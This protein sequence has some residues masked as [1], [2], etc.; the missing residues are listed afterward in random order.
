[1]S[2]ARE[3]SRRS[4]G[5]TAART[6]GRPQTNTAPS[7][8]PP[9]GN[10]AGASPYVRKEKDG[11][12][13][14]LRSLRE[15]YE[16]LCSPPPVGKR[17]RVR[18][19][20]LPDGEDL[21]TVELHCQLEGVINLPWA[22][23][24]SADLQIRY[25]SELELYESVQK[26][27]RRAPERVGREI[28]AY[29]AL[30]AKRDHPKTIWARLLM[31]SK[32]YKNLPRE[33]R[34]AGVG[35]PQP[36]MSSGGYHQTRSDEARAS[37][38]RTFRRSQVPPEDPKRRSWSDEVEDEIP[39]PPASG[40]TRADA[41]FTEQR[42]PVPSSSGRDHSRLGEPGRKS[43]VTGQPQLGPSQGRVP[44]ATSVGAPTE[45]KRKVPFA[46]STV[47]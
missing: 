46:T 5:G 29:D 20:I 12:R 47:G 40:K 9:A 22:E 19:E 30:E 18:A 7:A 35:R 44:A 45:S 25:G 2:N 13:S 28:S 17:F 11:L 8:T 10:P 16:P 24:T 26:A 39:L 21:F 3:N 31:S 27:I 23:Y 15:R 37:M 4:R 6:G 14:R 34:E 32:E 42:V 1:M 33:E 38:E 43:S 41:P 36:A